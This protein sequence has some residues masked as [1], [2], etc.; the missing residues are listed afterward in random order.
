MLYADHR[1]ESLFCDHPKIPHFLFLLYSLLPLMDCEVTLPMVLPP[2]TTTTTS[3][4]PQT[5]SIS[6]SSSPCMKFLKQLPTPTLN[7]LFSVFIM[8]KLKLLLG[9]KLTK[10][11]DSTSRQIGLMDVT[12]FHTGPSH[13]FAHSQ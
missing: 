9:Q 7:D 8:P 1:F 12:K 6:S 4:T 3:R 5:C 13:L 2:T 11:A 10:A